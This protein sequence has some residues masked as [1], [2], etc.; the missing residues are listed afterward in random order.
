MNLPPN[1]AFIAWAPVSLYCFW[2]YRVQTAILINFIAGWALLP[3][4]NFVPDNA[5]F[6]YWILG[7]S[8]PS[9]YFLTKASVLGLYCLLGVLFVDRQIFSRFKLTFWDLP[10]LFWCIVPFF[11]AIANP[12]SFVVGL[13]GVLYLA[14]A[15]GVPYLMGR[16]YFLD[17]G[18]LSLLAKGFVIA[19]LAYVPVCL[20]EVVTGPRIYVALYGYQPYRWIGAQ[21]YLGFRPI[22]LLEDGNQL[23]IWMATSALIALGLWRLRCLDRILGIPIAT[24]AGLLVGATLLCQS[25]GSIL[26][27]FSLTPFI[28]LNKRLIPRVVAVVLILGIICFAGLRL[29]SGISLRSLVSHNVVA[30]SAARSLSKAGRGSFGWRLSQDERYVDTA[31]QTPLVGS[32][33]WDWWKGSSSRPWGLWMLTFGMYGILGLLALETLQLLSVARGIFFPVARSTINA[34]NLR[35]VLAAAILMSAIDSLLNSALILPLLLAVGSLSAPNPLT[36]VIQV[37]G[38]SRSNPLVVSNIS[39]G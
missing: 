28:V 5:A 39:S 10:I 30:D 27:L 12:L 13:H 8:L 24:I 25:A 34:K 23:G 33:E 1:I 35:Y 16:L 6:P 37:K 17:T 26:L 32:G 2:K 22:G 11:S 21:R 7:L 3:S 31:L 20:L 36:N 29:G 38:H 14:L 9:S 15:W 4:A 19:G 18:S